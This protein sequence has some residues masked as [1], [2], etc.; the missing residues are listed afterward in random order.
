MESETRKWTV[1][2]QISFWGEAEVIKRKTKRRVKWEIG[3]EFSKWQY[4]R[5]VN[6]T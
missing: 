2:G 6:S 4:K 5:W 3:W 1:K